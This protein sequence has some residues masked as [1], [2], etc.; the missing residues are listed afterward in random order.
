MKILLV[1]GYG[2]FGARLARLLVADGHDVCVAGRR[3]DK[4]RA[5]ARELGCRAVRFDRAEGRY[6]LEGHDVVI[7]AAGPFHAYGDAP[8]RLARAA[9]AA[10]VHYLDLSDDAEFC[11]GIK[12]LDAEARAAGV[13]VLSGLSSVPALSSAAVRALA[14]GERPVVIDTAILPGNRAPRGIS[15]MRSILSQA[16]RPMPVWR[17]NRWE[18]ARG[19][20]GP[21]QY[22]LPGGL[23]RQGWQIGVPDQRLFPAHFGAA[24]V[25]FRAG[26][27]LG[28]MRYGLALFAGLRRV[29]PVP[30]TPF[31]VRL[32]K[33]AADGLAPF[34]SGR[35]GMSVSVTTRQET[36]SWRLLAEDGDGP[37]IPAVAARA[38][39]RRTDLPVGAG[40]A[41]EVISLA[42]AEAAM[43]DLRVVTERDVAPVSFLF[44]SV[45]GDDFAALPEE[46]R[47]THLTL[48]VSRW[49][50]RCEVRRGKGLWSR[51]LCAVFRFP[52]EAADV[53]VEVTKTVTP[54][55]E[56]WVR[57]F[58]RSAFRS[59][60][61]RN[62][63]GLCERFGPFTFGIG[64]EVRD[65]ALHYPVTGGRIGPVRLPNWL[66]P[67]SVAREFAAEGRFHFDVALLA[68]VTKAPLVHY[69]GF[70]V[71][72]AADDP[73][74]PPG[75]RA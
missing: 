50:G 23:V 3:L 57:R 9:V 68:P 36:R 62:E 48:G 44:R 47:A 63:S 13:C 15:V 40:P 17:G 49:E 64:L 41:L 35:G 18:W 37:F 4:A 24:T 34:G 58:G 28:V 71:A 52:P 10:G 6:A 59:H 66:L 8:Y 69:R 43:A 38:L 73:S 19:W 42:E 51:V 54:R 70:L 46:I 74:E 16:G 53:P 27:E 22:R 26:L 32:F 56:T 31:V 12:A 61:S 55:G 60:L 29:V 2:V 67:G 20:S 14:G 7:D 65:G 33:L 11:A 25:R 39:L 72:A 45:L 1:G 5:R 75:G 30:V 21:A